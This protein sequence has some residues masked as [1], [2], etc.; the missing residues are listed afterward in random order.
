MATVNFYLDKPNSEEETQIYLFFSYHGKRPQFYTGEKVHP[1]NWDEKKQLVKGSSNAHHVEINLL[2]QDYKNTILAEYTKMVRK[3]EIITDAKLKKVLSEI[4]NYSIENEEST[5]NVV[6]WIKHWFEKRRNSGEHSDAVVRSYK[7]RTRLMREFFE[8]KPHEFDDL[9]VKLVMKFRKF[10]IDKDYSNN[11]CNVIIKD[12]K[13]IIFEATEE[14][15]TYNTS[16]QTK[17]FYV[18][19]ESVHAVYLSIEQLVRLYQFDFS[20]NERLDKVRDAFLIDCFTGLRFSDG[21]DL[22]K[23]NIITRQNQRVFAVNTK[24]GKSRAYIPIHPIVEMTL[25]K[26]DGHLPPKISDV[27]MNEYLKEVAKEVGFNEPIMISKTVGGKRQEKKYETW[28]K[29]ST[30][31]ARRSLATNLHLANVPPKSAML[32]T[33]HSSVKQYMDYIK[34]DSEENAVL[35]SKSD[36]FQMKLK[37]AN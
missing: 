22:S 33:G 27:K 17:R 18:A 12:F 28:E 26:Y 35:L 10:L 3:K 30:H 14:G 24:K 6:S 23:S 16:W 9:S 32:V 2:L 34:I 13:T 15:H 25:D 1:K 19:A 5:F 29:V 4:K 36:F 11:Y 20:D 31:T 37:K 8:K 21:V 7:S